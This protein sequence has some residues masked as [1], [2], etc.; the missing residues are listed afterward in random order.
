M[1]TLWSLAVKFHSAFLFCLSRHLSTQQFFSTHF[2]STALSPNVTAPHF[3]VTASLLLSVIGFCMMPSFSTGSFPLQT[4]LGPPGQNVP[5]EST[6]TLCEPAPWR[7]SFACV[8]YRKPEGQNPL[9]KTHYSKPIFKTHYSLPMAYGAESGC[10]RAPTT[11]NLRPACLKSW[12]YTGNRCQCSALF[13]HAA[14]DYASYVRATFT[15]F[16]Q[17]KQGKQAE[18]YDLFVSPRWFTNL[19]DATKTLG[20]PELV[21]VHL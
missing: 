8:H 1:G 20:N 9:F 4:V 10:V 3:R 19:R 13:R 16:K 2:R 5:G 12:N 21:A 11:V 6:K 17:E 14:Y 15:A 7:W 18:C